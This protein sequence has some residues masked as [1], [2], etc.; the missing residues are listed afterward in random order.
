MVAIEGGFA[1][2]I[3]MVPTDVLTALELLPQFSN[4]FKLVSAAPGCRALVRAPPLLL[5]FI[6]PGTGGLGGF[7]PHAGYTGGVGGITGPVA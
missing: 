1:L 5:A 3:T 6:R 4:L 2:L 7:V